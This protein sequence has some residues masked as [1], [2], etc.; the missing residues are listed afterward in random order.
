MSDKIS[1]TAELREDVGKGASRRLR[2]LGNKVPAI[3]YGAEEDP[4][5]LTLA[6]NE[7][8]KAMEQEAAPAGELQLAAPATA[9]G[10]YRIGDVPMYAVDAQCRRSE[11]LQQTI[12]A[13]FNVI[14]LNPADAARLGLED[15]ATAKVNQGGPEAEFEVTISDRVPEGGAWLRSATCETRKLGSAFAPI[16]V[17]VA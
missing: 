2:R 10:L 9:E 13:G 16:S 17:E 5:N 8:T 7:L 1:L 14:G 3:I 11:P 4:Q 15:G 6:V 12:H